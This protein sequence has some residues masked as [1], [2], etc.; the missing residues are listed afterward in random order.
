MLYYK[1]SQPM[2]GK[3]DAWMYYEC[4]DDQRVVRYVTYIPATGEVV[5]VTDPVVKKLYKPERLIACSHEEFQESW[6][7]Q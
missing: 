4:T 1:V 6:D 5:R 2:P 7:K 3:G